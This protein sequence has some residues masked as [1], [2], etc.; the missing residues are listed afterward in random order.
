MIRLFHVHFSSRTLLLAMSE[1]AL[2]S[3]SLFLATLARHGRDTELVLLYD[4]GLLKIAV[5]TLVCMLCMHYYDLYDSLVIGNLREVLARIVQVLG[6]A[7][8]VLAILYFA[9][10]EVQ[11]GRGTFL[12][13]VAFAA[14]VLLVSR[15]LFVVLNRSLRLSERAILLGEGPLASALAGEIESRSDLGL[16]LLGYVGR[17]SQDTGRFDGLHRLGGIEDLPAIVERERISRII[18]TMDDRRG[19]L[20]VETLL[21]LKTNGVLIEDA[22]D[23]YEAVTGKV[24]LNSLRLSWLLFSPGFRVS[25][26]MLLYKRI[27]SLVFSSIG[28]VIS[29]PL[30]LLIAAVVR[31]DSPG[32]VI[33]RQRRIGRDGRPF[34]LYKFRSMFQHADPEKPAEEND[35]RL[36]GVG[37]WLRRSR[38][39]ELPQL[40]NILRGDMYFVGP[41]PF[42]PALEEEFIRTIPFYR[43][44]LAVKPGATGW[45]QIHRGYCATLEENTDRL[46][47]DLFY[48]RNMS[49]GLD[50]LILF[51]T[52]K[53]LLLGRG[54]R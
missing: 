31:L 26:A 34:T 17:G 10:P 39:D 43:Q 7:C 42:T 52:I 29:F 22:P 44:R 49:I 45:A 33:F 51:Q 38:L 25:R 13:W 9:Y 21:R 20:P 37:H 16:H 50:I 4:R 30:M 46:A 24:P 54:A 41:R 35:Q 6:T 18:L 48:I 27:V 32:P 23:V 53:I 28:I 36:T 3:G 15:E 14:V 5:A 2:I 8:V 19:A 11:L 12:I 47:Y 40:Y 1:A